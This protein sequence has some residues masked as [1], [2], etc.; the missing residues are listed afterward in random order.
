MNLQHSPTSAQARP[1][2]R[3]ANPTDDEDLERTRAKSGGKRIRQSASHDDGISSS[4]ETLR[5]TKRGYPTPQSSL[6]TL[7]GTTRSY[8][9]EDDEMDAE[10][11]TKNEYTR[12][13]K[14]DREEA[15]STYGD[16]D[17][18][19]EKRRSKIVKP[20]RKRGRAIAPV[21]EEEPEPRV[22]MD[23]LCAGK[24]IGEEWE[25]AG[26]KYKVGGD[27]RRLR[28]ASVRERRPKY[29]MVSPLFL[30]PRH[31]FSFL[32]T[33]ACRFQSSRYRQRGR[34]L[35]REVAHRGGLC[36]G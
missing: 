20:V 2:K 31:A 24:H 15:P 3:L 6:E 16:D 30:A 9:D 11:T 1:Q 10:D 29:S 28:C 35:R 26:T 21:P 25:T 36:Q 34:S 8:G 4:Q 22:S 32:L 13:K 5:D 12:G 23:P 27:G 14:R 17:G 18:D 33:Q 7:K 19:V